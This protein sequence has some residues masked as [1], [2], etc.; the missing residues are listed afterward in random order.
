MPASRYDGVASRNQDLRALL[1]K[2]CDKW[3]IA[4]LGQFRTVYRALHA[5]RQLETRIERALFANLAAD[6]VV[7]AEY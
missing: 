4:T 7:K 6:V 3:G 2:Q 1:W 5:R